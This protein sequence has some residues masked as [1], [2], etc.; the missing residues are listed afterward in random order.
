MPRRPA[1]PSARSH[2]YEPGG[3]AG[4]ARLEWDGARLASVG[5]ALHG[6]D[7]TRGNHMEYRT[8]TGTGATVSRVS[9]GTMTFGREV[10][11]PTA[12]RM[13]H[14][15]LDAG[16]NL[17]DEADMYAD[18]RS[19]EI[20]GK[21]LRGRRDGVVLVSKVANPSGPHELRDSGLHRW[22]VLRGVEDILRRL[23]TDRL[24]I[25]YLHRPDPRTPLEE[26]LAAFD[27]L[28]QQ[29]KVMYVGMSNYP[30]WQVCEA[31]YESRIHGW[32]PPVVTQYPYNLLTR[33]L[34]EEAT[35]FLVAKRIGLTV[36]NPL[37]GGLLTGKHS[38]EAGP[39]E[40]T[41]LADSEE[42]HRRFWHP[43]NFRAIERLKG[44]A[45]EAGKSL[46]EL[47]LQWL[48]TQPHVDSI[49]IG[50]SR[51]EHLEENLRAAE[52]RLD[53]GALRACDEVWAELRGPHFSYRR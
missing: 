39:R 37:A 41:R 46:I 16:V 1:H 9:L 11:E 47:S 14:M 49:V 18:G 33:S 40:R 45:A 48:A 4:P 8:L 3:R 5:R 29:G 21:A 7:H 35:G 44:I 24:D 52:G 26:T 38:L 10:D 50:A 23:Q 20:V 2:V 25:L 53:D 32:A 42:Y 28:V 22:H 31:L 51:P 30:A 43:A 12:I 15:A 13:V 6:V 27:S 34:D 36:Y 19:E 17:I